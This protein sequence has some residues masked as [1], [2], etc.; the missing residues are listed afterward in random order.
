MIFISSTNTSSSVVTACIADYFCICVS[1]SNVK[2]G[3]KR[4]EKKSQQNMCARDFFYFVEY[5]RYSLY[6]ISSCFK[7]T[8]I[9]Y[10][11]VSLF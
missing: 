7:L 8:A 1:F 4:V 6:L 2:L 3:K 9:L 10:V 5:K 11:L